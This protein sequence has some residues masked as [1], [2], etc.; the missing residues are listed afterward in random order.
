MIPGFISLAA[1]YLLVGDAIKTTPFLVHALEIV[2]NALH[3]NPVI[4]LNVLEQYQ[5]TEGIFTRL[6]QSTSK[7]SRVHDKKLLI[8]GLTAVLNIPAAQ[9][10]PSLQNGLPQ[11]FEA[12]LHVFQSLGKAIEARD[13]LERMYEGD[14][15]DEAFDNEFEWDGAEDELD[16][17]E[18]FEDVD[19]ADEMQSAFL[20]EL[21]GQAAK[22]LGSDEDEADLNSDDDDDDDFGSPLDEEYTL[23]S[24]LDEIDAYIHLQD[25][26]AEM[27]HANAAV[28]DAIVQNLSQENTQFVQSLMEE[29]NRQRE[30]LAAQQ[31]QS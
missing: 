29:A 3:Y 30:A 12:V 22:A 4:T 10:P 26:L 24:P 15:D 31:Q 7:F 20:K 16:G 27:Q 11:L 1:A 2:L 9:L 25:K 23:E 19:D 17:G 13:A 14:D 5:W 6:V 8:F 18:D 21:A 28:Y